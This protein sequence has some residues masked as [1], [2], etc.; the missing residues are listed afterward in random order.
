M[1]RKKSN[2]ETFLSNSEVLLL[3]KNPKIGDSYPK[4]TKQ[5]NYTTI[6]QIDLEN[7]ISSQLSNL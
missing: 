2:H 7:K 3:T 6:N 4:V 5:P 1:E